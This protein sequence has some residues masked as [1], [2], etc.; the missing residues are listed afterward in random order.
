M[1]LFVEDGTGTA[2]AD[3]YVSVAALKAYADARGIAYVGHSDTVLEQKVRE[4]TIYIDSRYRYK[5]SRMLGSQALEYPRASLFDWSGH[6]VTGVPK[7][8]RDAC[9]ELALKA[10]TED[11]Y[12]DL[13]R[14][15]KIKSESVGSLSTTYAD[16]APVG[17]VW[18]IA[19]NLLKQ[20]IKS[21]DHDPMPVFGGSTTGYF[22]LGMHDAPPAGN[23][24]TE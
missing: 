15:G 3:A 19:E 16:D 20:Y 4:A 6:E 24:L 10:L 17:K 22:G 14:G 5:G 23:G 9:C 8:V 2:D 18:T 7:R 21:K 13:D 1:A 12:V 11:L